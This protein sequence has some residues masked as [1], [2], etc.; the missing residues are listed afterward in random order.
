MAAG[1]YPANE[2]G[3]AVRIAD[4]KAAVT[5]ELKYVPKDN[6]E[7]HEIHGEEVPAS[8]RELPGSPGVSRYELPTPRGSI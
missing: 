7:V 3:G 2:E 5:H 8:F 4:D 1:L 6:K